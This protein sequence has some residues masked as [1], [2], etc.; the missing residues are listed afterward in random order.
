M[1]NKRNTIVQTILAV[2]LLLATTS[3][4]EIERKDVVC[5]SIVKHCI[6]YDARYENWDLISYSKV[7]NKTKL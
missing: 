1:S 6:V 5:S 2:A 4:A 7:L 3:H